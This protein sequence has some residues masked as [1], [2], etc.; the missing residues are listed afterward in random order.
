MIQVKH[1]PKF[2]KLFKARGMAP[3]KSEIWIRDKE[4]FDA[5]LIRNLEFHN[6]QESWASTVGLK[7]FCHELYHLKQHRQMG[8][9]RYYIKAMGGWFVHGFYNDPLER[10]AYVRD[11]YLATLSPA[12]LKAWFYND[13]IKV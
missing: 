13:L 6:A 11:D 7:L 1:K 3:F 2:L 10:M 4:H 9:F 12:E 8:S 5:I